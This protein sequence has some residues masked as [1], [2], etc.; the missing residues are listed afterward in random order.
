MLLS[1]QYI[2]INAN[3][4]R[5]SYQYLVRLLVHPSQTTGGRALEG[6]YSEELRDKDGLQ[7]RAQPDQLP[8]DQMVPPSIKEPKRS[9][10]NH[11]P[12][13]PL[14]G[15]RQRIQDRIHANITIYRVDNGLPR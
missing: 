15:N 4:D 12:S 1:H 2:L 13:K 3:I 5:R 9:V 7:V 11:L 10:G 14:R 6:G 8:E